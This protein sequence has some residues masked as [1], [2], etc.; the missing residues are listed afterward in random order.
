MNRLRQVA[1]VRFLVLTSALML[2]LYA[3]VYHP[4]GES[5]LPGR[6]LIGYLGLS[7]KGSAAVLDWL[8]EPVSAQGTMVTGRFPYIVVLDCAALDAQA[9]FAAAVLAFPASIAAKCL[10][11]AAGLAG[12]WAINIGRLVVL[13]YAGARS[14]DL[15]RVLHEEIFVF[16]LIVAVCML[17]LAWARWARPAVT[18]LAR[19]EPHESVAAI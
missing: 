9:L 17:F 11:L 7:A 15:F 1:D 10:G 18:G 13:Y 5:S 12:I 2:V 3:L 16:A 19:G 14:I 4:Y 6:L 8:G